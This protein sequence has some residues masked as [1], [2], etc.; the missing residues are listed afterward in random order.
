[1]TNFN[2]RLTTQATPKLTGQELYGVR[3]IERTEVNGGDWYEDVLDDKGRELYDQIED[4]CPEFTQLDAEQCQEFMDELKQLGIETADV[5]EENY[6]YHTDSHNAEAEFAEYLTTELN[7]VDLDNI[8]DAD[9]LVIVDG[10]IDWQ[11]TWDH[12]FSYNFSSIEFGN[13]TYFFSNGDI[14]A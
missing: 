5:F 13:Q 11:G 10:V 8:K 14:D 9:Y 1:M 2:N 12:A 4:T 7:A 6:F 3:S